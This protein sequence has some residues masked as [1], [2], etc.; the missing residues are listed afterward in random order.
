VLRCARN[1]DAQSRS[2][3]ALQRPSFAHDHQAIPKTDSP[4]AIQGRRSAERRIVL[5]IA[6]CA[7]A[8]PLPDTPAFRRFTA[9]L[10]T[11][12][13]PDGS[14]PEPGFPASQ[15]RGCFAPSPLAAGLAGSLRTGPCAGRPVPQSRPSADRI[16]IRPRAPHLAPT[17]ESALAKGA[18]GERDKRHVTNTGTIVKCLSLTWR[19]LAQ[20][21]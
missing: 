1:D 6:A 2:R 14:A 16:L 15:V 17:S 7:A 10:A 12:S 13:Y 5:P 4:P 8:H 19:P 21:F 11:G 18:L 3:G 9:A 20:D